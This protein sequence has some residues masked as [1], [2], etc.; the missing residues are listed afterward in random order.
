[1][2]ANEVALDP[3]S[4]AELAREEDTATRKKLGILQE[5]A[6]RTPTRKP[7]RLSIRFLV[8]PVELLGDE[9]GH[10]RAMRI[11]RNHL[12]PGNDGSIKAEPTGEYEE[13][14]VGLVFRSV[15]YKGVAIPGLSFDERR[16]VVPHQKGRVTD[17]SGQLVTGLYVSGWI[18]RGP[19]GVIGTN[20][21]DAAETA[22]AML[23][24]AAAGAT[25]S[26]T[27]GDI[28]LLVRSRQPDVVTWPDWV[29]LNQ[30]EADAG[31]QAGRSR[32]KLTRVAEMLAAIR[33]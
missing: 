8:S 2:L 9:R 12:V 4:E 7:K 6:R 24:D 27:A 29:R 16:G 19:S 32:V 28:E 10:V 20:K 30:A 23:E 1:V 11:V 15:G 26:P 5:Y 3:L 18:K 22:E 14:P 17:A 13:L 31:K 33:K 25:L 21:P